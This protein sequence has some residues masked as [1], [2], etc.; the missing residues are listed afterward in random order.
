MVFLNNSSPTSLTTT[1][2]QGIS[3]LIM[4]DGRS[5]NPYQTLLARSLEQVDANVLFAHG[6]RRGL[7]LFREVLDQR[8]NVLHLH[9]LSPY[10]KGRNQWMYRFYA[11]KFI[12]DVILVKRWGIRIVWTIH[13]R[14]SHDTRFPS[15]ELWVRR[16]LVKLADSIVL[17]N[18]STLEDLAQEYQ[19]P[20]HKVTVIPHGHYRDVYP[21]RIPKSEARQALGLPMSGTIFLSLGLLRPYKGIETLLETWGNHQQHFSNCTL[22][23][24]GKASPAYAETLRLK[25]AAL[26]NVVLIPEFIEDDRIHLFFSAASIAVLPYRQILNSGSLILAMSYGLPVVAPNLG[27]ISEY[28]DTAT[29]LLF[30]PDDAQGLLQAMILATQIDLEDIRQ[31][32][33][34]ACDRLNWSDI[35]KSTYQTYLAGS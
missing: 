8:P 25:I 30:E 10:L 20:L 5:A 29:R 35:G 12:L 6:Y 32:M 3:V 7:P 4:P 16:Q 18:R 21:A 31:K 22:V 11:V 24:A 27:G 1:Q 15:V 2:A 28:L 19:F 23:I 17:H 34:Q 33:I 13:N 14:I 9:W 26:R